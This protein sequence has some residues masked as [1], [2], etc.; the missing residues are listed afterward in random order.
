MTMYLYSQGKANDAP[1]EAEAAAAEQQLNRRVSELARTEQPYDIFLCCKNVGESGG[2][3]PESLFLQKVYH[4]LT[5]EGHRVFFPYATL[6]DKSEKEAEVYT[7]FALQTASVMVVGGSCADSFQDLR[8]RRVWEQFLQGD[9]SKRTLIPVYLSSSDGI[10]PREFIPYAPLNVRGAEGRKEMLRRLREAAPKPAA[11]LEAANAKGNKKTAKSPRTGAE[12]PKKKSVFAIFFGTVVELFQ[13]KKTRVPTILVCSF[14]VAAIVLTLV[15]LLLF[16]PVATVEKDQVVYEYDSELGG[17]VVVRTEDSYTELTL[18]ERIRN[19]PVVAIGFGAFY[20]DGTL[21]SIT[22][23]NTVKVIEGYAL[24]A[25]LLTSVTIPDSVTSIG[26][27]AFCNTS[28]SPSVTIP[29]SVVSIGERAFSNCQQLRAVTLP[30]SLSQLPS[31]LFAGCSSLTEVVLPDTVTSIGFGAFSNC[32][33]LASI[34]I[35]PSVTGIGDAAF[36]NCAALTSIT[37]PDAV[38]AIGSQT[39]FGCG[40]LASVTLPD[41]ITVIGDS[42]FHS[43]IGLASVTLP[44]SLKIIDA[45]AFSGCT[46][47]TSITIPSAVKGIQGNAFVNC[48]N[49]AEVVFAETAGWSRS[50]GVAISVTSP[51]G[52]AQTLRNGVTLER[53]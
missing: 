43:C 36:R 42:A 3:T 23:P 21:T 32:V 9:A 53:N 4:V 1:T 20:D 52:I 38:T 16:Y 13:N 48:D 25:P 35:P 14:L 33:N 39:F 51:S 24:A 30:K 6:S 27:F 18:P 5:K 50:N 28:L 44:Q 41:A 12:N 2:R 40:G 29:D 45:N 10:L 46:G 47:L 8:V 19:K 26:E 22:I 37:I 49:L 17:Y 34:T 31:H 7:L 15:G 11:P